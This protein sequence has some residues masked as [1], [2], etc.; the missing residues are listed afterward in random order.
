MAMSCRSA[1]TSCNTSICARGKPGRCPRLP[2]PPAPGRSGPMETAS[3]PLWAEHELPLAIALRAFERGILDGEVGA[4]EG[5]VLRGAVHPYDPPIGIADER[6]VRAARHRV[7]IEAPQVMANERPTRIV[8]E[9]VEFFRQLLRNR[10]TA[11]VALDS[12][13]IGIA[14]EQELRF[15]LALRRRGPY[16]ADG[17][18]SD[19]EKGDRDEY[20]EIGEPAQTPRAVAACTR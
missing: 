18:E 11:I 2:D 17:R 14:C 1:T 20:P 7:R 12:G 13:A 19:A 6:P 4:L 9:F 15:A 5:H 16:G 8:E 10:A 3:R